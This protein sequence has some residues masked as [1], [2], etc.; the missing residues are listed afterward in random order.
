MFS[1]RVKLSLALLV[2][3]LSGVIIVAVL[4]QRFTTAEFDSFVVEQERA[5]FIADMAA[6]YEVYGSWENMHMARGRLPL[7]PAPANPSPDEA[8]SRPP[9]P[10][11]FMLVDQDGTVIIPGQDYALGQ[12]IAEATLKEAEPVIVNDETVG[13]VIA[14]A[15]WL[16]RNALEEAYLDRVTRMLWWATGGAIV[17]ALLLSLLFART[18]SRPLREIAA[19]IRSFSHGDPVYQVPVRSRDEVG[20]VAAA[21][22]QMSADLA[23][24]NQLRRQ[25]IADIAHELRTPLSVV[26]GY[27][28]SMQEGLLK[29]SPERF[30]VMHDEAQHLQRLVED[31]RL[32]SLADAGELRLNRQWVAPGELVSLAAAAF[33]HQ[34]E[35]QRLTLDVQSDPDVPLLHADPDRVLQVLSNLLSNALR[36]TPEGGQISLSARQQDGE[37]CLAVADTGPGIAP[38]HLPHIFERF[39]RVDAARHQEQAESGLGLAIAKSLVEAHGGR[40]TATSVLGKGTTVTLTFPVQPPEAQTAHKPTALSS[41]PPTAR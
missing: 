33:G 21:F 10:I 15:D 9:A 41:E 36:H 34:A 22:N 29:P 12:Q 8:S 28:A 30:R 3:G 19:A 13:Y 26:V 2:T 32:L 39:Y 20:E 11:R 16:E 24:A 31:L 35:Q 5:N 14:S 18:L 38:E 37:I 6:Y 1:L 4:V 23:R 27:L 17:L 7:P 25:M 40:I